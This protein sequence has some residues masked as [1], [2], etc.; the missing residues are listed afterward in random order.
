MSSVSA[1]NEHWIPVELITFNREKNLSEK[2]STCTIK[3][4]HKTIHNNDDFIWGPMA[5]P[6]YIGSSR[7]IADTLQGQV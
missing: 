3:A 1:R 2:M 4:I 5:I 6:W 7:S